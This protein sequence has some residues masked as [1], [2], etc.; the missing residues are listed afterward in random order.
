MSR[1]IR[2]LRK[3]EGS[4]PTTAYLRGTLAPGARAFAACGIV[5][6]VA[7]APQSKRGGLALRRDALY[8]EEKP[9][10][11]LPADATK[12][13]FYRFPACPGV[14]C[15]TMPAQMDSVS[16][17]RVDAYLAAE[18]LAASKR[19]GAGPERVKSERTMLGVALMDLLREVETAL[20]IEF[21]EGELEGLRRAV[22]EKNAARG[23]YDE[24]V[25][26]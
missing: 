9:R 3:H 2:R 16:S 5:I 19:V 26:G 6:P 20:R 13:P 12:G 22:I 10:D 8:V 14:P 17:A 1:R 23:Y 15:R 24:G 18:R 4:K 7:C 11:P 25:A 21:D